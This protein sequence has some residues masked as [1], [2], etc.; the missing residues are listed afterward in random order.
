MSKFMGEDDEGKAIMEAMKR[1]E[2]EGT[3]LEHPQ[4]EPSPFKKLLKWIEQFKP[5]DEE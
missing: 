5:N 1:G 4:M 2:T 3:E